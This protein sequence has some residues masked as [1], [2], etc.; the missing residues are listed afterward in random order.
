VARA[1]ELAP[2]LCN[3]LPRGGV[4]GARSHRQKRAPKSAIPRFTDYRF[5]GLVLQLGIRS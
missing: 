4:R 5:L 2:S 1:S 3:L